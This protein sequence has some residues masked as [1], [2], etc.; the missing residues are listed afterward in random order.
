LRWVCND[1]M[2]DLHTKRRRTRPFDAAGSAA[3]D[4]LTG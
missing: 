3:A 4:G 2:G 1:S